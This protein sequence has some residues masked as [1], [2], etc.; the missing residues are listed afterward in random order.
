M[1]SRADTAAPRRLTARGTA[2][3][4]RIIEAAANLIYLRGVDGTSLD[5]VMEVSQTSKSQLYHYF[6]DKYALVA[7]VIALQTR[8]VLAAQ[9]PYLREV[10]SL[11]GLRRWTAAMVEMNRSTG[12]VGGCPI[13]SL[14]SE[15]AEQSEHARTLLAASFDTWKA[16]LV[17]GLQA[18]RDCGDLAPDSDPHDLATAIMAALQGGLL[19]AQTTRTSRPLEL[20]LDMAMNHI[21]AHHQATDEAPRRRSRAQFPGAVGAVR[22]PRR[23][24]ST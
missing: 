1:T 10:D 22:K 9:E 16:H 11:E 20:A 8:R 3:R 7:D 19:L 4:A 13:G 18:M 15:L 24:I 5:E 23:V 21:T 2:T 17:H 14:A 12:G 6:A